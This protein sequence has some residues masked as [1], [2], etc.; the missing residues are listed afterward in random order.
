[1]RMTAGQTRYKTFYTKKRELKVAE[2][3]DV[4][5]HAPIELEFDTPPMTP[6]GQQRFNEMFSI[7]RYLEFWRTFNQ[8]HV[9]I[10]GV[11]RKHQN[12]QIL[13]SVEA[14]CRSIE[15]IETEEKALKEMMGARQ[16]DQTT[17][18]SSN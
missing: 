11:L 6:Q 14:R 9:I 4:D 8:A 17:Y 13:K 3:H 1:M 18:Q 16:N 2:N 12:E 5:V 7:L 15:E 10:P